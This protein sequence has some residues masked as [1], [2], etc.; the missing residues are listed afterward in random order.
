MLSLGFP[1]VVI[2]CNPFFKTHRGLHG[3]SSKCHW[4]S[5]FVPGDPSDPSALS[6][7]SFAACCPGGPSQECEGAAKCLPRWAKCFEIP[8]S[9]EG[10][11]LFGWAPRSAVRFGAP[12]RHTRPKGGYKACKAGCQFERNPLQIRH[13]SAPCSCWCAQPE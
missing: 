4:R 6:A 10:Y 11:V 8:G 7:R 3:D 13:V 2:S 5:L 9:Q 1:A 12:C